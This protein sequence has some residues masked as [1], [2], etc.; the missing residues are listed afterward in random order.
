MKLLPNWEATYST[1]HIEN[2]KYAFYATDLEA[3]RKFCAEQFDVLLEDIE[4]EKIPTNIRSVKKELGI[5]DQEIAKM[6][7]YKN[8]AS[9]A[10]STRK[11][12]IEN[13][14]CELYDRMAAA[15]IYPAGYDA[16]MG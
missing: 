2:I 4:L 7:G 9:Y 8:A 13:G 16:E 3:A 10:H 14:I 12:L 1:E 15:M 6:F 11:Q 5:Q